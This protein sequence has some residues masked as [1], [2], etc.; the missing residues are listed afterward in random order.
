MQR[1]RRGRHRKQLPHAPAQLL[2]ATV[3]ETPNAE[4]IA[5]AANVSLDDISA[6]KNV[7]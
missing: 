1:S 5:N 3:G 2:Q 6:S 4:M 7:T